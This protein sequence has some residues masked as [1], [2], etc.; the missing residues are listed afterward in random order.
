LVREGEDMIED[1][2]VKLREFLNTLGSGY[3]TTPTG[4]EIRILK[5]IFSPSEAKL[6]MQ[7]KSEPEEV[8]VIAARVGEEEKTLG[9]RLEAMA[10]KGLIYRVRREDRPLYQAIHFIVGIY[11]FQL[12]TLDKELSQ[13]IE[14]YIPYYGMSLMSVKTKQM[15]VIPVDS[16]VRASA[17]VET[18][19]KIRE[20]VNQ[21][22][23]FS[24]A[25]CICR[26]EQGLLGKKCSRP[27]E[28]CL[29]FGNF[30]EFY[31]ENKMARPISK[32]EA[33]KIL[34]LAE[35]SG[36]V[37]SPTN[38]QEPAGVCC[39]CPCC[40]PTLRYSKLMPRPANMVL[41]YYQAK[42]DSEL[43]SAC[44]QCVDRCQMAAIK[45]GKDSSEVIDGRCIGCGLC[46]SVCPTE[47]ISMVAKTD[48]VAPP[49]N[50]LEDTLKKI[51]VERRVSPP[52]SR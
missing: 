45:E 20:L 47:A 7:L 32:E 15:R 19:N 33:L 18:Y 44:G 1:V 9:D 49:K 13:M 8:S 14:E 25:P 50:F 30:A 38:S 51:E 16:S 37:L 27:L 23:K 4:V 48:M 31:I 36:L 17:K 35:E 10:Q 41:S 11:E 28:T 46:V 26:K 43:C 3:P 5:K 21:Q 42:I 22:T 24:V 2:Y 52:K 29:G 34:D 39:C 40:C 12:N 6:T